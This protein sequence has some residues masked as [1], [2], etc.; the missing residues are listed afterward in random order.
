MPYTVVGELGRVYYF[1]EGLIPHIRRFVI[2]AKPMNIQQAIVSAKEN[3]DT[4]AN[5]SFSSWPHKCTKSILIQR[6][7]SN[8]A[9]NVNLDNIEIN[10]DETQ[11][12]R[13]EGE[14]VSADAWHQLM[15][16]S[17]LNEEQK[18]LFKNGWCFHCKNKGWSRKS[19]RSLSS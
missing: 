12:T 5:P 18:R 11:C 14:Q 16:L 6:T 19:K 17:Q 1:L 3:A 7:I 4:F 15:L 10:G 9:N 13:M 8:A 2:A